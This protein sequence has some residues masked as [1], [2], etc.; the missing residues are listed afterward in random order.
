MQRELVNREEDGKEVPG[1]QQRDKGR[2]DTNEGVRKLVTAGTCLMEVSERNQ[3]IGAEVIFGDN[4]RDA[5]IPRNDI[6]PQ[7]HN[8][9]NPKE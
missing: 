9:M 7:N 2:E 1:A 4:V 8:T 6:N 3:E 5:S